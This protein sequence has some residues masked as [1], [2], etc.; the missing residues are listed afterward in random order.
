M[1]DLIAGLLLRGFLPHNTIHSLYT[2]TSRSRRLVGTDHM[3]GLGAG[4]LTHFHFRS[5]LLGGSGIWIHV[6]H[7]L[8]SLL[9]SFQQPILTTQTVEKHQGLV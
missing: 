1:D 8:V 3:G 7:H 9:I 2:S 5:Y 4:S 6:I